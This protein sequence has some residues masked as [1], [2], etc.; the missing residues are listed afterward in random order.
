M[1][2]KDCRAK[3]S[4]WLGAAV[5][6]VLVSCGDPNVP[7]TRPPSGSFRSTPGTF[8]DGPSGISTSALPPRQSPAPVSSAIFAGSDA[9]QLS[10]AALTASVLEVPWALTPQPEPPSVLALTAEYLNLPWPPQPSPEPSGNAAAQSE[11]STE[12]EVEAA[13]PDTSDVPTES[14]EEILPPPTPLPDES[15][16]PSSTEIPSDRSSPPQIDP[17][18]AI[19]TLPTLAPQNT[20]ASD[21][22]LPATDSTP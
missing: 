17:T 5:L 21:L 13:D 8:S 11:T 4:P 15:E 20:E 3:R 18:E 6:V 2:M 10:L 22:D 12:D 14:T 9:S 19:P 7:L 1:V 16:T